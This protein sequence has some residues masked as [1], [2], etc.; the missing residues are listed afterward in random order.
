MLVPK[1][2]NKIDKSEISKEYMFHF[3]LVKK[4]FYGYD[5]ILLNHI[6]K[7]KNIV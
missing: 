7:E 1:K 3:S 5:Y 4:Q 2:G 6:G